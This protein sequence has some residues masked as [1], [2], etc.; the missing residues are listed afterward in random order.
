MLNLAARKRVALSETQVIAQNARKAALRRVWL[1]KLI[2]DCLP[3]FYLLSGFAALLATL[4]VSEWF[5]I[6]P[7]CLLFSASCLQF[8]IS[9]FRRRYKHR[10]R[11]PEQS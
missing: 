8:G 9:L 5:W 6:L 10:H 7:Y 4:Y 11:D 1:P 2:Y 3:Y